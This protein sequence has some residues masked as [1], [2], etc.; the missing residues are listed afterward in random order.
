MLIRVTCVI[1]ML[2]WQVPVRADETITIY[3]VNYPLK[4]F[5][6]NIAGKHADV[7]FPAPADVDPAFWIPDTEAIIGY[8]QAD[9]IFLNGANYANWIRKVSLPQ[10]SLLNT[11]EDFKESYITVDDNVTHSHGLEGEHSHDST[12]FTTW[13]DFS[14][15]VKHARSIKASL[16]ARYPQ[17]K[18]DFEKN[19]S[20]LEKELLAL[21]EK[22]K[23][24]FPAQSQ[25]NLL[26]SHPVYHY[27]ARRY[28]L[29]IKS[30]LWEPDEVPTEQQW[31]ELKT[32]QSRHMAT[33]MLWEDHP[34]QVTQDRLRELGIQSIV[35]DPC[36]N[37]CRKGGFLTAMQSNIER[38]AKVF[39]P[40]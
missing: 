2:F 12:F 25:F 14:Q 35:F 19:F 28:G 38:L 27:F 1:L 3:T 39:L 40:D 31:A 13:L 5:A 8:Q 26:A 7:V 17:F 18:D 30:V 4:Y 37:T 24:L 34:N 22:L 9:I 10:S 15:A 29:N 6:E 36:A 21:D 32:I 16:A 23:A 11:S 33:V 20:H